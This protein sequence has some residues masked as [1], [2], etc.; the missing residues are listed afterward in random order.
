[1]IDCTC[2]EPHTR[3][4]LSDIELIDLYCEAFEFHLKL[5]ERFITS[6]E[7][8]TVKHN[9]PAPELWQRLAVAASLR[10]FVSGEDLVYLPRVLASLVQLGAASVSK[11]KLFE[12]QT[13]FNDLRKGKSGM[14]SFQIDSQKSFTAY[15]IVEQLL[16]TSY[17]HAEK[18]PGVDP[19]KWSES[20]LNVA[21]WEGTSQYLPFMKALYELCCQV[22]HRVPSELA[23]T[24]PSWRLKGI[25]DEHSEFDRHVEQIETLN[26]NPFSLE[27]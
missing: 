22:T 7:G 3:S 8:F 19:W 20:M 17:L 1:M 5:S 21:L 13:E 12:V 10:K 9:E 23:E 14:I 16:H 26:P 27:K 15:Q 18:R 25:N 2:Q 11:T 24:L 6:T 4:K